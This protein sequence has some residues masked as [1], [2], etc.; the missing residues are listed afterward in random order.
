MES[1]N[2]SHNHNNEYKEHFYF[3]SA[4]LLQLVVIRT[5][6]LPWNTA[7]AGESTNNKQD[8]IIPAS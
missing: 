1:Y 8:N 4:W 7:A 2:N 5:A 3:Y 6:A